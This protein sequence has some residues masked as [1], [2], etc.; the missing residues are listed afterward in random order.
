MVRVSPI[1]DVS[2]WLVSVADVLPREH[3]SPAPYTLGEAVSELVAYAGA[4]SDTAWGER[5]AK[6]QTRPS[7]ASEI[8]VQT[9]FL[10]SGL[11]SLLAAG[12]QELERA[13]DRQEVVDSAIRLADVW[14][15]SEAV[16]VAFED[17]CQAARS[18]R[19]TTRELRRLSAILSSQI[20]PAAHGPLSL[21]STAANYLV[22]TDESLNRW[23]STP[24][25]KPLTEEQRLR[26]AKDVLSDVPEGA[27]VVWLVFYRATVEDFEQTAGPITFF[28]AD[29]I[30]PN[31][32]QEG[33][34]PFQGENELHQIRAHMPWL[35]DL[36]TAAMGAE[37]QLAL[38]RVD[39]GHRELAGA[40]QEARRRVGAI[41]SL[42]IEAGGVSWRDA[43]ACA[44][45]LDGK[46]R[47]GSY[48]LALQDVPSPSSEGY[49]IGVSGT[50][51]KEVAEQLGEALA[52]G[53]M[54]E[55]LVEALAS[56]SEARMT[57][58]RDVIFYGARRVSDRTATALEDHAMELIASLLQVE[59]RSLAASLQQSEAI[60]GL[61]R[62]VSDQIMAPFRD[63]WASD[64]EG[65]VRQRVERVLSSNQ[66]RVTFSIANILNMETDIR[67]LPMTWLQRADFDDALAIVTNTGQEQVALDEEL[68]Q[69]ELLRAR[70]RR[71]R[72]A[73]NHG[74][75]LS[76]ATLSSVRAYAEATSRLALNMALTNFMRGVT[77]ASLLA[78]AGDVLA[79]RRRR[80]LCRRNWAS[81]LEQPGE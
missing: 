34:P 61:D 18:P 58:H 50:V 69:A 6:N 64:D 24:L 26:L 72:N 44:A 60:K 80:L 79:Q 28:R 39:L 32:F 36:Y 35:E 33:L 22:D 63:A 29:W 13:D 30:L 31:V 42:A 8:T 70:L 51:L 9:K 65:Q 49:G 12:L 52:Q 74:L 38:V 25:P 48:G 62:R 68:L 4:L 21:L 56:L 75:P 54:S 7:L 47:G 15:S 45:L 20:G 2:P 37:H 11:R 55:P 23:R 10:G 57:D 67:G 5:P 73:V 66:G 1:A 40:V 78:A 59:A 27:V 53:P 76:T 3:K 17:L 46:V 77:G 14:R 81:E 71:V 16:D 43:T 41:L 19:T